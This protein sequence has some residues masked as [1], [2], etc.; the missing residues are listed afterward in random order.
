MK[1][2]AIKTEGKR[3]VTWPKLNDSTAEANLEPTDKEKETEEYRKRL[4]LLY[5]IGQRVG[6]VSEVSE[7][8]D[9]IL[10]MT[11]HT[12]R[13]S[14]SALLLIDQDRKEFYFEVAKGKVSHT[15]KQVRLSIDSGIAGWVARNVSPLISNDVTR[16]QRFN[17]EIDKVTGFVTRSVIAVPLVVDR[18]VVG[19]FEVLNKVDGSAFDEKDLE[20]L[21]ALASI[22]AVALNNTRLH[23]EIVKSYR[24]TVN[25]L[26]AAID[27][28]DPYT[29]GHSQRVM[30]YALLGATSLSFSLDE[31]Q[32]VEFGGL[33]H[34]VGKIGI[35]DSILSKP[36]A[37]TQEEW[38]V[39][40]Q[41]P[42]MGA[43]IVK[44][45]PFLEKARDLIL[46]HHEK[47]DGTGYLKGLRGEDIPIGA[48]LLAVAD[49][50]DTMTTDRS[51]RAAQSI[52]TA[53]K[54]LH[55]CSGKQFCPVAVEAFISGF[56][57]QQEALVN[58]R[59]R[60]PHFVRDLNYELSPVV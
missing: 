55:D 23:Q 32:A 1:S 26:I 29:C 24:S 44:E 4:T 43:S 16:D 19:V 33:L 34:D 2:D 50:F 14:A 22:A 12:L 47:Y 41:H 27:A 10:R 39:I 48:R 56:K 21:T 5:K 42:L 30:K 60:V 13:A 38:S 45:I 36:G 40:Y 46:Y 20:L 7:L 53:L 59:L 51:Y 18:E 6:L 28:K 54:E 58:S 52:D 3:L 17:K 31:L 15:L 9:Q 11:H 8:L 49:A 57:K 37:L 35:K 25:A